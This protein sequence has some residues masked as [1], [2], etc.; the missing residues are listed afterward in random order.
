MILTGLKIDEDIREIKATEIPIM[1]RYSVG[2]VINKNGF[3]S[4]Y[5]KQDLVVKQE[6]I[7]SQVEDVSKKEEKTKEKS[8]VSLKDIDDKMMTI[9]DFLDDFDV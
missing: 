2:S 5:I 1:E 7:T 9:D 3:D 6:E 4:A 8:K